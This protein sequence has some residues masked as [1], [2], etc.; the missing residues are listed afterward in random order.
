MNRLTQVLQ[1]EFSSTVACVCGRGYASH[2]SVPMCM[3]EGVQ[4]VDV[5]VCATA[6]T[7][8]VCR[9]QHQVSSFLAH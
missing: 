1:K 5:P 6:Q 8:R 2:V 4:A 3:V 9:G 7:C